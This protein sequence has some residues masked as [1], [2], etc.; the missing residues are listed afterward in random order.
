MQAISTVDTTDFN[1]TWRRFALYRAPSNSFS[2]CM[3]LVILC[4]RVSH[5]LYGMKDCEVLE[6]NLIPFA[7]SLLTDRWRSNEAVCGPVSRHTHDRRRLKTVLA[8]ATNTAHHVRRLLSPHQRHKY[9]VSSRTDGAVYGT[10]VGGMC[11]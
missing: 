1:V 8:T 9:E 11:R 7:L 6:Y 10:C 3:L 5:F 4:C 2:F